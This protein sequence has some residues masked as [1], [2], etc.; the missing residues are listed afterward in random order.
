M[1][2]AVAQS[3]LAAARGRGGCAGL[4]R[5]WAPGG[6]AGRPGRPP[7]PG[8]VHTLAI[9]PFTN[10]TGAAELDWM[11][12]GPAR[13]A[14]DR[15]RAV[16][17]TC[18]P[19]PG[20][21]VLHGARAGRPRPARRAST[22]PRSSPSRKLAHAE[23]VLSGQFVESGGQLRLDLTL[24]RAGSG[25]LTPVKVE[26]RTTD[27]FGAGGPDH[28]RGQGA[29][30]PDRPRRS[31]ATRTGRS[32]R[33]RPPRSRPCA[34]TRRGSPSCGRA[35]PRPPSPCCRRPPRKDPNFAMA[36][37]KL[38]QAQLDAGEHD[39]AE[40]AVARA[41]ALAEKAPLPLA[42]RYQIHATAALRE[43]RLRDGG[44]DLRRAGQALPDGP[45][46]RR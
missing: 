14:G 3:A 10:A 29:P 27:V 43:G 42:E 23:S 2:R 6:G 39:A 7:A 33:S 30:R 46:H 24:R 21:R 8:P 34:P 31:A 15:P 41:R 25:V 5:A 22:R 4:R 35:R 12:G 16:A 38:A 18:R 17:A 20:E 45:R 28:A 37:A 44:Q 19:V 32:P 26:A 1:T 9:L 36:F 40:A 11:R 13:D